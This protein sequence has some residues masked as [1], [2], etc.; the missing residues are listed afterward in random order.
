GCC[1]TWLRMRWGYVRESWARVGSGEETRCAVLRFTMHRPRM[2]STVSVDQFVL[3]EVTPLA[4]FA[5]LSRWS[6][7]PTSRRRRPTPNGIW[8]ASRLRSLRVLEP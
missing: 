6:T 5:E 3:A 4:A 1:G 8:C 7:L 2:S